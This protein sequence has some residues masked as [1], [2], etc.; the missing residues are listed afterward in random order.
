MKVAAFDARKSPMLPLALAVIIG[1]VT[2]LFSDFRSGTVLIACAGLFLLSGGA[3]WKFGGRAS[4]L[5]IVLLFFALLG[6]YRATEDLGRGI[7]V[8][9]EKLA[10][11]DTLITVVGEV[12]IPP[13]M[14]GN[15]GTVILQAAQL[16]GDSDRVNCGSLRVRVFADATHLKEL[17][18]GDVLYAR[19]RLSP[20]SDRA[21]GG[22]GSI[23]S[24]V[25]QREVA[26]LFADSAYVAI[27]PIAGHPVRRTVERF[28]SFII[29]TFDKR[30]SPDGAALCKAL[31]LGDR[32]DFSD[33]FS[34][35]LR[36][37][38]LSHVFALSGMNVG[39][40]IA[41][42][43]V[44]LSVLFIPR[45]IRLVILLG[46]VLLYME[47][48]RETPSL[49]RATLMAAVF[50]IGALLHRTPNPFNSVASAAFIELL[51]RPLDIVDAGF[52]LSY[53]AVLGLLG[54][55]PYLRDVLFRLVRRKPNGI[56]RAT[57]NVLAASGA[58]QIGTLPM[59]GFFFGR[60]PFAG[61]L[62]NIVAV[63][64]F[65]VLLVWSVLLLLTEAI[66]PVL[67]PV[68]GATLDGASYLM[69]NFVNWIA[70]VPLASLT[71][72][73]PPPITA[74]LLYVS[75][76]ILLV[77]F[78]L[79]RGVWIALG[80][81]LAGNVLIWPM[82]LARSVPACTLTFISVGNGDAALI[83]TAS[84]VNVLVDAGPAIGGWT[85]ADRIMPV[86][87]ER[88]IRRL[89][90]LILTH[91]DNDHIGGSAEL[92]RRLPVG[93]LFVNGD[94]SASL[95]FQELSFMAQTHGLRRECLSAG[96][97]LKLDGATT[98]FVLSP[99]SARLHGDA[100]ENE[101]SLLM[102]LVSGTAS[103]LLTADIDSTVEYDVAQWGGMLDVDLLKVAHHGSK[104]STSMKFLKRTLPQ[105]CVISVGRH[106]IYGH[107]HP[108]VLARLASLGVRTRLTS[109]EGTLT[110]ASDSPGWKL[111]EPRAAHLARLWKL[112]Y[113]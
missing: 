41:M 16:I 14:S 58:A 54:G 63:P 72:A 86:L 45:V 74:M 51:W 113:D 44:G 104:A 77:G 35:R 22:V 33:A 82:V 23:V 87:A 40:L 61:A 2:A 81:L 84:G 94:S 67:S 15:S 112:P 48:G 42:V 108:S 9:V 25:S 1:I 56:V 59:T 30:L 36:L 55:Y 62:G 73:P 26:A 110:Y 78:T 37:T 106:N 76:A 3:V 29:H 85:A 95:A 65:G 75:V 20:S 79:A 98:L 71:V 91:P 90:A 47:L 13:V 93:R 52:A 24:L 89:D 21:Q 27:E 6:T 83:S 97:T 68:V 111:V 4:A 38:G 57:A 8:A 32:G 43:W 39:F 60:V 12:A 105:E 109:R 19:G 70:S 7:R 10:E 11:R 46:V 64:V 88:G 103:A 96:E 92:L 50:V 18:L 102:R 5:A 28:R 53:L 66:V 69:G 80:L 101:K 34:D 31:V 107:P 17:R 49:V 99:D 100:T